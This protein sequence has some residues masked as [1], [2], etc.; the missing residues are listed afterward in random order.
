MAISSI[1]NL[2][3]DMEHYI[4]DMYQE[5]IFTIDYNLLKT[6]GIKCL[7]WDLDNTIA[8]V[9]ASKPSKP[10][11]DLFEKLK[12]QKFKLILFSNSNK[13]RL[14]PFK[15]ILKVDCSYSCKKPKKGKFLKVIEMFNYKLSE[16]AIIGDQI[17]TDVVG[18]NRVGITTILIKPLSKKDGFWTKFNRMRERKILKK[19][20][21]KNILKR[22]HYYE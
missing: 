4:P 21:K 18:G 19:L 9:G 16:V 22:G 11:I 14:E 20:S 8:L 15:K 5:S 13:K 2:G 6:R 7:L 12:K 3:D 17:M 1:I 10:V